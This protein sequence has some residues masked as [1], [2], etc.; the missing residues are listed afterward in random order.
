VTPAVIAEQRDRLAQS[1]KPSSINRYLGTLSHVFTTAVQ[2]WQ[3]LDHNPLAKVR[4]PRDTGSR[5]RFLFDDERRRLLEACK[6]SRNPY[7][8]LV[9]VLALST[10]ARKQEILSLRWPD[11][12]LQRGIITLHKTKNRNAGRSLWQDMPSS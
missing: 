3:L 7:L 9:V 8:Y 4:R 11:V 12:D 5:I 6:E 1:L 10:G 2:E